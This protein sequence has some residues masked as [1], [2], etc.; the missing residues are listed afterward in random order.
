VRL[1]ELSIKDKAKKEEGRKGD[2]DGDSMLQS[3]ADRDGDTLEGGQL[4]TD[5]INQGIGFTPSLILKNLVKDYKLAQKLYGRTFIRKVSGYDPQTIERNIR[6]PE[7]KK[8]LTQAIQEKY[9]DLKDEELLD[10]EGNITQKGYTL[11]SL[12]LY[13]QELDNLV[14]KG[15]GEKKMDIASFHGESDD[16]RRLRSGDIYRNISIRK[17]I[18]KAVKRGHQRLQ[19]EDIVVEER[20]SKGRIELMYAL[21]ASG[22]MRGKKLEMAKKSGIALAYKAISNHDKVGLVVFSTEVDE[23]IAPTL[24]FWQLMTEIAKVRSAKETNLL[25]ALRTGTSLFTDPRCTRHIILLTDA[26]PTTGVD[27]QKGTLE[28]ASAAFNHGITISLV[29][30]ELD[31]KGLEFARKLVEI[32]GGKLYL[33]KDIEDM[34]TIVLQDYYFL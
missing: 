4:I 28:A 7:F 26:M 10:D 15:F 17:S 22:S 32:G 20:K 21:D 9:E 13:T 30:I 8:R 27:P 2:F 24:D 19:V 33:L 34:D 11:S 6:F 23:K 14:A 16:F 31:S 18:K 25:E 5:M 1:P 29:G 3:V 12:V